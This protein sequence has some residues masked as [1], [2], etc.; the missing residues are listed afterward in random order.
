MVKFKEQ[1]LV[2]KFY[3]KVLRKAVKIVEKW[4]KVL[5][6][7]IVKRAEGAE[8]LRYQGTGCQHL[9][10]CNYYRDKLFSLFSKH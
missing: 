10:P 9:P 6:I 3:H 5:K 7:L 1:N 2:I 4:L 8:L